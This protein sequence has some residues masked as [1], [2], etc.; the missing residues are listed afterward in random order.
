MI[1]RFIPNK[2]CNLCKASYDLKQASWALLSK[3]S[4]IDIQLGFSSNPHFAAEFMSPPHSTL[5]AIVLHIILYVKDT[6][7]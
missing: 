2:V 5:Y 6:L 7:F 3:F 1:E 4:S